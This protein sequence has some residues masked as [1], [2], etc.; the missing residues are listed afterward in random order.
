MLGF[1]F[2]TLSSDAPKASDLH[3]AAADASQLSQLRPTDPLMRAYRASCLEQ[4]GC[5]EGARDEYEA[6]AELCA[7]STGSLKADCARRADELQI[8]LE[9]AAIEAQEG[10]PPLPSLADAMKAGHAEPWKM[11]PLTL[12]AMRANVELDAGRLPRTVTVSGGGGGGGG[13]ATREAAQSIE[14]TSALSRIRDM[15]IGADFDDA[16]LVRWLRRIRS[17]FTFT[18]HQVHAMLSRWSQVRKI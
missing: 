16:T 5:L 8:A 1:V 9:D 15:G 10:P 11:A 3:R 7:D 18:Q 2:S 13:A 4:V 14:E 12:L 17:R 6:A